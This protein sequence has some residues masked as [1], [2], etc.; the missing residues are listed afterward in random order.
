VVGGL[1][2]LSAAVCA[3]VAVIKL[4]RP[5]PEFPSLGSR[6]RVALIGSSVGRQMEGLDDLPPSERPA[7]AAYARDE[8]HNAA[9][10]RGGIDRNVQA[11][12]VAAGLLL[13]WVALRRREQAQQ[14]RRAAA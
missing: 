12:L 5:A 11:G 2:L 13:G 9:E 8:P 4:K 3:G 14:A 1:L 10:R 6:L 7:A